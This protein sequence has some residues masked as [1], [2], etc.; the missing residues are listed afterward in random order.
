MVSVVVAPFLETSLNQYLP[1][2]LLNKVRYLKER[3]Y[4][5]LLI[6]ALIFGSMHFNSLFYIFY[7]FIC[8][9]V[10]MYGY[11]VRIKTDKKTYY[12]IVICHALVNGF[13]PASENFQGRA[14]RNCPEGNFSEGASLQG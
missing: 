4:L 8:G 11:M 7:G 14:L 6:S 5:I 2:Y 10:L 12:L 13:H 9:L 3:S 1:Y